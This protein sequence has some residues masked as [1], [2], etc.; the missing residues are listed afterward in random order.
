M[1]NDLENNIQCIR[2]ELVIDL[3]FSYMKKGN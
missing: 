2:M 3:D 1:Y